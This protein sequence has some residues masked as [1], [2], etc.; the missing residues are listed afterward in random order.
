[1]RRHTRNRKE[2]AKDLGCQS[3]EVFGE[4]QKD[5]Y[6]CIA[7]TSLVSRLKY[8]C[9]DVVLKCFEHPPL[10]D[11]FPV[12]FDVDFGSKHSFVRFIDYVKL[13][14]VVNLEA[15]KS[16]TCYF[17]CCHVPTPSSNLPAI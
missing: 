12:E 16:I 4:N 13:R 15:R 1:M 11:N 5:R 8:C 6:D 7:G 10:Q 17:P 2:D 9:S 14:K 3:R